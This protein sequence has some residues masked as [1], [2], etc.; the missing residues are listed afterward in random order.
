MIVVSSNSVKRNF[1]QVRRSSTSHQGKVSFQDILFS[2]RLFTCCSGV[3]VDTCLQE[4]RLC[5]YF[6]VKSRS[7]GI[8]EVN[9]PD[10]SSVG[11]VA[12]FAFFDKVLR[13]VN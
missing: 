7:S 5:Y 1:G 3:G 6:Q 13:A 9:L 2:Q 8:K 10:P 4:M 12:E 11:S